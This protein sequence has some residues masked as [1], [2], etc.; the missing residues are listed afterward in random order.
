MPHSKS[1]RADTS[2]LHGILDVLLDSGIAGYHEVGDIFKARIVPGGR[3]IRRPGGVRGIHYLN[4]RN[5]NTITVIMN[6]TNIGGYCLRGTAHSELD[7]ADVR[8]GSQLRLCVLAILQGW[9]LGP[10]VVRVTTD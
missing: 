2:G 10:I 9:N 6:T 7:T 3:V 8:I 5:A 1:N 4:I